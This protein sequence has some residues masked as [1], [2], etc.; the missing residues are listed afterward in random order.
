MASLACLEI[1]FTDITTEGGKKS[2]Y[3]N[4]TISEIKWQAAQLNGHVENSM[5]KRQMKK[6][7]ADM[8]L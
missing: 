5:S 6:K 1:Q 3:Q 7:E 4:D 8:P 2:G